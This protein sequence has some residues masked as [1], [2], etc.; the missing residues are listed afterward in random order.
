[1][2]DEVVFDTV[3]VPAGDLIGEEGKG[4]RYILSGISLAGVP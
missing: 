1:L 4:F 3:R 2:R